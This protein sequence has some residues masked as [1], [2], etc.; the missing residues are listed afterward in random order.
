M[1]KMDHQDSRFLKN[2]Q[3]SALLILFKAGSAWLEFGL[4]LPD[5]YAGCTAGKESAEG[6]IANPYI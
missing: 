1:G 5:S 6:P 4:V 2:L 3:L